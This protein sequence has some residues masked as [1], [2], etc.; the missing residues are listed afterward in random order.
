MIDLTDN[1][2]AK[3]HIRHMIGGHLPNDFQSEKI[4]HVQIPERPGALLHFLDALKGQWNVSL[5]HYRSEGALYGRVMLGVQVD[6][7]ELPQLTAV[8]DE[9]GYRYREDSENPAFQYF[10]K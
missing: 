6:D 4:F 7:D 5:F 10:L 9:V 3:R 1:E 8:M 2:P